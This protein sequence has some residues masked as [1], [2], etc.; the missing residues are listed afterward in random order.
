MRATVI[1]NIYINASFIFRFPHVYDTCRKFFAFFFFFEISYCFYS[2]TLSFW[3]QTRSRSA[4]N[5]GAQVNFNSVEYKCSAC[6]RPRQ[7]V[8]YLYLYRETNT[9]VWAE[10]NPGGD[11]AVLEHYYNFFY[12]Y[13]CAHVS[14][15]MFIYSYVQ[16]CVYIVR[17]EMA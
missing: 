9:A 15:R 1:Q 13:T 12:A 5:V 11:R 8:G 2:F 6:R 10:Q 14:R 4:S 16:M 3:S 17:I 7:D